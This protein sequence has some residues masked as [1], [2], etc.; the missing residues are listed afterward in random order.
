[1]ILYECPCII[2]LYPPPKGKGAYCFGADLVGVG[3]GS[4]RRRRQRQRWRDT[5]L[6]ARYLMNRLVDFN[7][8]CTD[9][10]LGHDEELIRFW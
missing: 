9:V 10:T 1:M 4:G 6:F 3:V 5:F 8:I 7:L 2:E